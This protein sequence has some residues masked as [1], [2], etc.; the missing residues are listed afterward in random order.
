MTKCCH[1]LDLVLWWAGS[2]CKKISSFGNLIHFKKENKPENAADRCL[3][4]KIERECPYSGKKLYIDDI[5]LM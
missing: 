4:C 1:D 2:K 3:D 5:P